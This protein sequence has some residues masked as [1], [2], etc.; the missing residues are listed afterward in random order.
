MSVRPFEPFF[1]NHVLADIFPP[2]RA[3]RFF[4]ALLGDA[5]EGAYDISLAFVD[6]T[7]DRID[8][9]FQLKKRP[10]RC[11]AC[12]LTHGLPDVFLRHPVID[13]AGVVRRIDERISNGK[14]CG[15]WVLGRTRDISSA[16]HVIPL[17]VNLVH[18]APADPV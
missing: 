17:T 5:S 15:G 14:R 4:E 3:D 16:M 2:D 11:L 10:G 1:P 12:N 7:D 8:F 9:E 18:E 13:I 6:G